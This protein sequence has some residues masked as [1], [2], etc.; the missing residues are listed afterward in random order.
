MLISRDTTC[1]IILNISPRL[2]DYNFH[3]LR[4]I[5]YGTVE[6]Q[7]ISMSDS[8]ACINHSKKYQRSVKVRLTSFQI[9]G[10][11]RIVCLPVKL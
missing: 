8:I 2:V 9:H 3:M 4:H 5:E 1:S 10:V 7:H 6:T 11:I